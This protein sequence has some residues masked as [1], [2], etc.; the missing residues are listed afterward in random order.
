MEDRTVNLAH[1]PWRY[2]GG[3]LWLRA[4]QPVALA[5]PALKGSPKTDLVGR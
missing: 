3:V 1:L 4:L 2:Q 5:W